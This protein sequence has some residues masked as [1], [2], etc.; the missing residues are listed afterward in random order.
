[1]KIVAVIP[2]RLG[3]TR[4]PRKILREISG[5]PMISWVYEAARASKLLDDVIIATD[6][7]EIMDVCRQNDYNARMT[8]HACKSGTERVYEISR[9]VDADV[10][11]NVQGDEPLTRPEH[12]DALVQLMQK[13]TV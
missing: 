11:V 2:A 10:Y 13:K 9:E 6:S 12:L 4:L 1:M 5:K 3:S 7:G 8:S